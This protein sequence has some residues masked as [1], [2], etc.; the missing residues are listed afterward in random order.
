MSLKNIRKRMDS[1]TFY[2]LLYRRILSML[3]TEVIVGITFIVMFLVIA[4]G[5]MDRTLVTFLA[6]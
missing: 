4:S 6:V 1:C 2:N 3:E 5:K